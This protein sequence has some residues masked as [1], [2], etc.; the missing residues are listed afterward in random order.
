MPN[1]IDAAEAQAIIEEVDPLY[2]SDLADG[3]RSRYR[4]QEAWQESPAARA[5]AC[6]PRIL[7]LLE[8]LYGRRP[9]PFQT[10]NFCTGT[11]QRNHSD[12]IHFSSQPARFMCG[13]W[14]ALED[15]DADNG[16][17]FYAPG[18]HVLPILTLTDL[19][20]TL[21]TANYAHYEDGVNA[22]MQAAGLAFEEVHVPLGTAFVWSAN[23]VHGGTPIRDP[24]RTRHSQVTH[25]F[26]DDCVYY[27]P[28]LSE[29]P[30]GELFV[31]LPVDISTGRQVVPSLNGHAV[32]FEPAREGLMRIRYRDSLDSVTDD[33]RA[34]F[35]GFAAGSGPE[36]EAALDEL[37]R[38]YRSRPDLRDAFGGFDE[39]DLAR[40]VSWSLE[41]GLTT[42]ASAGLLRP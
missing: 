25:Y 33:M 26:F 3:P 16:P 14:V 27:T 39:L 38:V 28:F 6:H 23:L 32:H 8:A 5:L 42:D 4:V 34:R 22:A 10:L 20:M 19:G 35:A 24:Q 18:S 29:V 21:A 41:H 11:Q 1:L 13:V 30:T 17:L 2:R 31:R 12:C 40:L 9:F 7:E 15:T 36:A 37:V